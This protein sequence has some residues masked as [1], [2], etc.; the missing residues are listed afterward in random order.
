MEA[1][2]AANNAAPAIEM[3]S[4]LPALRELSTD[5][6]KPVLAIRENPALC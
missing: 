2:K 4:G 6:K 5:P 1:E 3:N